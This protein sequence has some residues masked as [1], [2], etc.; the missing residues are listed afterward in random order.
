MIVV[1][2]IIDSV[3][4]MTKKSNHIVYNVIFIGTTLCLSWESIG[5]FP[6]RTCYA[7]GIEGYFVHNQATK[8]FGGCAVAESCFGFD[9]K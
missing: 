8:S 7:F 5:M 9:G 2:L 6:L 4:E 1:L 3:S